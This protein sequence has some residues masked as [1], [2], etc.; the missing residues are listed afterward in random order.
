MA[1]TMTFDSL[2]TQV[3]QYLSRGSTA[4]LDPVFETQ[5]PNFISQA[6]NR[7]ATELK[8]QGFQ[9]VVTSAMAVGQSVYAKPDRWRDTISINIGTGTSNNTRVFL[10]SRSYEYCRS[11]WPDATETEQPVFYA[12]YDFNHWLISPTPD[13][14]YPYE[15]IYYQLLPLLSDEV[16]TNW[17]TEQFPQLLLYAS[18]L[19]ATPFLK[20]DERIP[21]WQAMYDRTAAMVNGEDLAKI[22]D[23]SAVRK[24]A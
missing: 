7:I 21:T 16:Q 17:L 20:N 6:E 13:D 1:T 14:T 4:A 2:K 18:L 24:S 12:D 23:R 19:E 3:R 8:V 10:F 15:I 9:N 11:Y 22:L 5:L